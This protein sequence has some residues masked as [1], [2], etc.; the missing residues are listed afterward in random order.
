MAAI[1]AK[2]GK[3][4]VKSLHC[5][6]LAIDINLF[7]SDGILLQDK[8]SYE[9]FGEYWETLDPRN[10]WGGRFKTLVDSVHFEMQES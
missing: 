7:T 2:E 1:Y 6:R 3:G 8:K 4:I 10:R 9:P 5:D